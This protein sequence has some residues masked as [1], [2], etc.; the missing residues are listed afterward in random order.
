MTVKSSAVGA[1]K[2][3]QSV[4][5]YNDLKRIDFAL[6][7]VK[8]PSGRD[9]RDCLAED[10]LNKESVYVALPLKIPDF[11]FHHEVPGCVEEPVKDLFQGACTAYYAVR[12][13]SDVSNSSYG[14]TVSAPESSLI[15]YGR[16]RSCPNPLTR[17]N[18]GDRREL[19]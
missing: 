2:I 8:S 19:L 11:R 9:R 18:L 3:E 10:V 6:D 13:F 15:E 7:L 4:M 5:L 12:H 14:V 17:L 16:P 1:E